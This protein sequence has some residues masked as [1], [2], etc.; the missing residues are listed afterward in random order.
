[1]KGNDMMRYVGS[2]A[3]AGMTVWI[4]GCASA[5]K[6][7]TIAPVGPAPK[8]ATN[9]TGDGSLLVYSANVAAPIDVNMDTWRWNNDFGKNEFLYEAAHSDYTICKAN[10]EFL[11]RVYNSRS[12]DDRTPTLVSLPPGSYKVRAEADCEG[13]RFAV[14][15]PVVIKAGETTVAH[16][17]GGWKPASY[18]DTEVTKM[19]CGGIIGWRAP[20]TASSETPSPQRN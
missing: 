19:P 18:Q 6:V 8:E 3:I 15:M 5:P 14:L 13:N 16:L 9:S 12:P 20:E 7:T 1:M 11:E 10:G 4:A 2:V 17:E